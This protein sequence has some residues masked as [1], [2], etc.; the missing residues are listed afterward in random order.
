MA[1]L[2]VR[3]VQARLLGR[4]VWGAGYYG[5]PVFMGL[6]ALWL[7]VAAAGWLARLRAALGNRNAVSFED[8]ASCL[9]VVDRAAT[10]APSLGTLTERTRAGYLIADDG[11]ARLISN[12]SVV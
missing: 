11:V 4:S 10:R 8:V 6:S 9:G 7:N 5:W 3:Y 2:L 12:Y 1:D